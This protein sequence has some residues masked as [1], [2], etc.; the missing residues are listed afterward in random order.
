[1]TI[2]AL[3]NIPAKALVAVSCL[4]CV[5]S[6]LGSGTAWAAE[7]AG[8]V[9]SELRQIKDRIKKA[10]RSLKSETR[11]YNALEAQIE[12]AEKSIA[13]ALKR[14]RGADAAVARQEKVVRTAEQEIKASELQWQSS[15]EVLKRE[16]QAGYRAGSTNRA[17]MLLSVNDPRVI[18]RMMVY[19]DYYAAHRARQLQALREHLA[20]LQAAR[21]RLDEE[22]ARL[23]AQREKSAAALKRLQQA[24]AQRRKKVA[25]LSRQIANDQRQVKR[26][27][28]QAKKLEKILRSIQAAARRSKQGPLPSGPFRKLRGKLLWPVK[29]PLLARYGDLKAGGKMQWSG[30]WIS[31]AEGSPVR[32]VADGRVAYV[33]WLHRYGQ[34]VILDHSGNYLSLYGHNQTVTR[35]EGQTV[36]AGDAIATVG[37]TGG[38]QKSGVYFEIRRGAKAV[39]PKPWLRRK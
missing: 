30:L 33:G 7:D 19:Y 29:G 23:Q 5:L 2:I 28:A 26:L 34:I 36:S 1:M 14:K 37:K 4:I 32:A 11:K 27:Q 21:A 6:T 8:K 24:Q 25:S 39:N 16:L 38:H 35:A 17:K 13:E 22:L 20:A 3:G 15:R 10:D 12:K 18:D 9:S 31:A